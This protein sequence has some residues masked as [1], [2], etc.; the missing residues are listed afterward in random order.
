MKRPSLV[1]LIATAATFWLAATLS[2]WAQET[3]P[4]APAGSGSGFNFLDQL[5]GLPPAPSTSGEAVELSASFEAREGASDG[6]LH[7]T[8]KVQPKWH[9][10]SVTQ[11]DGGPGRTQILLAASPDAQLV[12]PFVPDA[13]PTVHPPDLFPV[14]VEEHSGTVVWTAPLKFR[15][16]V[17]PATLKLNVI[18]NGQICEEM[19]QCVPI[20]D[21]QLAAKFAGTY[22][23]APSEP[24]AEEYRTS[25]AHIAWRGHAD[26]QVATPGSTIQLSLT[27]IPDPGWHVYARADRDEGKISKPTLIVPLSDGWKFGEPVVSAPPLE[28]ETG[29][30]EEPVTRYHEQTV[31][32]TV[33]V[34]IPADIEAGA[35][36]LRGLVGYQVCSENQCDQM[37]A[38]EFLVRV[39]VAQQPQAGQVPLLL[40]PASYEQ[41]AEIA[42]RQVAAAN[43]S[44]SAGA[45]DIADIRPVGENPAQAPIWQAILFALLGGFILNF[46]PCVLPVI[47]LKIMSFVQQA[48]E[49]RAR[50]FSLNLWYTAGLVSVFMV[51]A[52]LAVVWNLSWGD[53]NTFDEFNIPMVAVVFAMGLSFLGVWE[54]P[55]PGFAATGAATGLAEKEGPAGAF[56]KGVVTTLLATPCSGPG[57]ATALA[58]CNGKPPLLVYM[59][60]A[61]MGLGMA[62]PYLVIGANP[63]LV[64]FLPKPG[65][66]M[67]TFKNVMGFVLLGTVIWI[68]SYVD[69]ANLLPTVTLL[70][71]LWAGLWWVGRTPL[72]AETRRQ[73]VAWGTGMGFAAFI[74]WVA[75]GWLGPVMDLRMVSF[76]DQQIAAR[77]RKMAEG[78][79]LVGDEPRREENGHEL[80]WQPFSEQTL[81]QVAAQRRTV[82]IDFTA[83]WCQTCKWLERYVLNTEPVRE[84]VDEHEIVPLVANKSIRDPELRG[85]ILKLMEQLGSTDVPLLAIF[86]AGRPQEPVLLRGGYTQ[87]ELIRRLREASAG[88]EQQASAA[89]RAGT[90][91]PLAATGQR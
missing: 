46:M 50:V 7:V 40:T 11:Q 59:V 32:W 52:T 22:Q 82:L 26:P 47:G 21:R 14:P 5:S 71:G 17:D 55:I 20:D 10:Y 39:E 63:R 30:P 12:G 36:E 51:L 88:G 9:I 87:A 80:P 48:G 85:E 84:V 33:P 53:Q 75:F 72:Y 83:D 41:A 56:F 77:E 43:Q 67:D 24:V 64:R 79:Q 65:A 49:S 3:T 27:A 37:T 15:E 8:A 31:T 34:T 13:P 58:W 70:F 16:G 81:K 23:S 90:A 44:A 1:G 19:G 73:L 57:I 76:V 6:R 86:P 74:G 4:V 45:L 61:F 25:G 54:I 60:F 91:S 29:L 18:F 28:K 69:W 35:H 2:A 68:L 66:W 62:M 89:E 38:A 78:E 42:E